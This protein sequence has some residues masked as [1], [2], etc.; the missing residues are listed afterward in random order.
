MFTKKLISKKINHLCSSFKQLHIQQNTNHKRK[1]IDN[2]IDNDNDN[3]TRNQKKKISSRLQLINDIKNK[4]KD[5]I[6]CLQCLK[7]QYKKKHNKDET[8][9]IYYY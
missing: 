4:Y 7:P 2:D 3:D 8:C 1:R 5:K 9:C 6:T